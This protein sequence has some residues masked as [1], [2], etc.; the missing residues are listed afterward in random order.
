MCEQLFHEQ[1]T[2]VEDRHVRNVQE[3]HYENVNPSHTE[4]S[5]HTYEKSQRVADSTQAD[6]VRRSGS[7][8]RDGR[9]RRHVWKHSPVSYEATTWSHCV[10][11]N[12]HSAVLIRGKAY[13]PTR[14]LL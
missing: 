4:M 5:L 13:I 2:Q 12:P 6:M 9:L 1:E 14:R 8:R 3:C 11:Q 10:A 7:R